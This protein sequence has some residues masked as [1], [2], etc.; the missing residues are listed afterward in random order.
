MARLTV[1]QHRRYTVPPIRI[2]AA[3]ALTLC[4]ARPSHAQAD[5]SGRIAGT[6]TD[7]V[8]ARPLAG[9]RVVAVGVQSPDVMRGA[10]TTDSAGRYHIDALP[11]GRYTVGFESPLLDS[12]EIAPPTRPGE[13]APGATA[14]VDLAVPPAAK[15]RA[16][17]CSG[18]ALPNETGAV[19][20]HVVSAETES[21]LS[22]A[23]VALAW[24]EREVDRTTLRATSR[25]RTVAASTDDAGWY[26]VCGVPTGTWLSVQL[27]HEGRTS[28]AIRAIVGD[29]L[30]IAIRHLSFSPSGARANVDSAAEGAPGEDALLSGTAMLGGIVRGIGDT[31]LA[32]AEVRVPGTAAMGFTDAQGRYS[33]RG[34]P[35]GTQVLEVRHIGYGAVE[36][37]VELRSGIVVTSDV[38]LQRIVNLDS[39]RIVARRSRY[40]DFERARKKSLR[41]IFLGPEDLEQ[42]RVAMTSDIFWRIPGFR[43]VGNGPDAIVVGSLGGSLHPCRANVVINGAPNQPI[44]DVNPFNIGAIA[45]YTGGG[46]YND[47]PEYGS[48]SGGYCGTILIWT[49][50]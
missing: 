48:P 27:Q 13:V 5:R 29:T 17:V 11:A 50:R 20:G 4:V 7:S 28:P 25:V 16:A 42:I 35:A 18:A 8:R 40:V 3:V 47:M 15:L 45:A 34:L 43:V 30:G 33:L 23:V 6:V 26:R 39:I 49:K 31:P 32:S 21:P 38:R 22:G 9:V 19:Y 10:A 41:G 1:R 12:L 24:W 44:N 36:T 14:T 2:F 46:G 37:S